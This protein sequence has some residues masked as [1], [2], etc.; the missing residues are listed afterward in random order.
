[1]EEATTKK[2]DEKDRDILKEDTKKK[3]NEETKREKI[4]LSINQD[5]YEKIEAKE[6][7]RDKDFTNKEL[8][9]EIA[10]IERRK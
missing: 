2:K 1:M 3:K 10:K 6:S 7:M 4:L 9:L 5:I 8:L